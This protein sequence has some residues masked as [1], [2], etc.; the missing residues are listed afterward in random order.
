MVHAEGPTPVEGFTKG[1]EGT[2]SRGLSYPRQ[3][4][5]AHPIGLELENSLISLEWPSKNVLIGKV[6]WANTLNK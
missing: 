5:D 6:N 3:R 4:G 1:R 2:G